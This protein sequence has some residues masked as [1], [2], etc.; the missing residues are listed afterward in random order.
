[1]T[2]KLY[3]AQYTKAKV[4]CHCGRIHVMELESDKHTECKCGA[5]LTIRP[6]PGGMFQPVAVVP[7]GTRIEDLKHKRTKIVGWL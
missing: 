5:S 1:M 4:R 3:P 2:I 6:R 7:D